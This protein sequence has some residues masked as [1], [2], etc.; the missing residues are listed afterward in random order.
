MHSKGGTMQ[1]FEFGQW[2]LTVDPEAG[3][4][5]IVL[6]GADGTEHYY[7]VEPGKYQNPIIR[8]EPS[9]AFS[10]PTNLTYVDAKGNPAQP[11]DPIGG[12]VC[13]N[14][15]RFSLTNAAKQGVT[16][17][18]NSNGSIQIDDEVWWLRTLFLKD[19]QRFI[20]S[21]AYLVRER[22]DK[23]RILELGDLDLF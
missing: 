19:K 23:V 13:Q 3:D 7:R 6:I 8:V 16:I 5:K 15:P 4:Y 11:S 12:I 9:R 10:C 17:K 2:R 22:P 14:G 1:H 21:D 20:G 18:V